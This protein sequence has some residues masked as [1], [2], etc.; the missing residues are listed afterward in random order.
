ME[1]IFHFLLPLQHPQED[2][3]TARE[4]IRQDPLSSDGNLINRH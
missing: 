1:F 4:R 2:A 3:E